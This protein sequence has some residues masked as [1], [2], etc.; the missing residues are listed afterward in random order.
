M[1]EEAAR[2]DGLHKGGAHFHDRMGPR[3]W[4]TSPQTKILIRTGP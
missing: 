3:R 2:A 1:S 4:F